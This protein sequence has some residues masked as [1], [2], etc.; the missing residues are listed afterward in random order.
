MFGLLAVGTML[1][2]GVALLGAFCSI[3]SVFCWLLFLPFK[4]LGLV[5]RGFAFLLLLPIILAVGI[6]AAVVFGAGFLVFLI[7]AAPFALLALAIMWIARRS[8]R[9]AYTSPR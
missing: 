3:L 4:L 2:V 8:S 1:V 6:F 5:F 9:P 7:P